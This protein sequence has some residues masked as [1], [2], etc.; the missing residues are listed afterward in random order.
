MI[1]LIDIQTLY[2]L[3]Y[4]PDFGT[5]HTILLLVFID[6][7]R[8]NNSKQR[9]TCQRLIGSVLG[10]NTNSG[11]VFDRGVDGCYTCN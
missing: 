8:I 6:G 7:R 2:D 10:I 3:N 9:V 5:P 11:F 1:R 4:D